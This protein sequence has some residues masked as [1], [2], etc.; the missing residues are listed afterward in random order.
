[1]AKVKINIKKQIRDYKYQFDLLQNIP[2]SKEENMWYTQLKK[3]NQLPEN[4][5]EYEDFENQFYTIYTPELT[6][7]EISEYLTYKKL[8][9]LNTIKNCMV[10]F[11]VL[12]I[13]SLVLALILGMNL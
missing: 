8:S 5:K 4:V 9:L 7:Q 11:T 13:I 1:M 12:T 6:E 3:E 2:C 10:F